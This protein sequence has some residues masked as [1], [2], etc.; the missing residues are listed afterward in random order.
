ML[1]YQSPHRSAITQREQTSRGPIDIAQQLRA[2]GVRAGDLLMVHASLPAIGQLSGGPPTLLRALLEC[3]GTDGTLAAYVSWEHSSYEATLDGR[4]LTA[5]ERQAWPGFEPSASPPPYDDAGRFNRVL[6]SHP[7]VRRSA[8]PDASIA[9]IGRLA[10][11]LTADH[12][13]LDGYGP[14]SPLGRLVAWGGKVLTLGTPPGAVTALH[15][16]QA[17]ARVP[18]KRRVRYEVPLIMGGE[19]HWCEAEEFDTDVLVDDF[20]GTGFDATAAMATEYVAEGH[21]R[22]G[23]V[24][25]A[26][27]WLFDAAHLVDFGARWL[28]E[29]FAA[30]R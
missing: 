10:T 24:G 16:A 30:R 17:I 7:G 21:G 26:S 18:G 15:L 29:R 13:L 23:R 11:D 9:A 6:C 4:K 1:P 2:V 20:A 3:I 12:S 22:R 14:S 5:Q 19:R 27:S 28:E 8:H 25:D